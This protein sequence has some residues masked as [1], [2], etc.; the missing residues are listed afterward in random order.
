MN[1]F[2]S[3]LYRVLLLFLLV[4]ILGVLG[5]MYLSND[6]FVNALYMTI[7]TITTVGFGEVHPLSQDEKL[8]TIFLILMS[9]VILGLIASVITQ[10]VASDELFERIKF[11]K[12]QKKINQLK[13]HT[14]V[15]GYGRNGKQA[16][17]KL[18]K[19]SKSL[20]LIENDEALVS[21]I[22]N[23]NLLCIHGNATNDDA[24][25]KAGIMNASN[26]ITTLPSDAD[27]LFV[28]LSARQ[29][30]KNLTIVSRASDDPSDSKLR[31]AGANNVIMPDKL[32]GDHMA[33]L[34]VT[35]D[36]VEFVDMLAVDSDNATHLEEIIV[37]NLPKE[38]LSKS[39]RDLDLRRK[40]GCTVIGFKTPGNEYLINPEADTQLVS[41]S[42]LIVLG[43]LEQIQNLNK[44]F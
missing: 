40:T 4:I 33:S 29:L 17:V 35:P 44:L 2:P 37:E 13:K 19:Y 6:T 43:S 20:V 3:N 23:D 26:L 42:K 11:K 21:E 18:K 24:L 10:Y 30:N 39:I 12:V 36:I 27:N 16:V 28:V 38:F 22:E 8:F 32:G 9:V 34:L 31:I 14:I 41:K 5:Y 25:I 1:N 15:C 7:I